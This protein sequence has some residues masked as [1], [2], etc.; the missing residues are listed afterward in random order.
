[1]VN[2]K[3]SCRDTKCEN[4]QPEIELKSTDKNEK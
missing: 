4:E 2:L 3:N 1:M